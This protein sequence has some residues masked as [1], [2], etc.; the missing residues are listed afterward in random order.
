MRA[1][2]PWPRI[3]FGQSEAHT[4]SGV[5]TNNVGHL[6]LRMP[7]NRSRCQVVRRVALIACIDMA[8]YTVWLPLLRSTRIR[9]SHLRL[10]DCQARGNP[11]ILHTPLDALSSA[12]I[13]PTP[14][15]EGTLGHCHSPESLLSSFAYYPAWPTSIHLPFRAL[16]TTAS[17]DAS[18]LSVYPH[19]QP[20][21]RA[22]RYKVS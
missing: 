3:H 2:W 9:Q 13:S 14:H 17:S 15:P 10:Y 1:T 5:S 20:I 21:Q 6:C 19:H 8:R 12:S 16:P 4:E 18:E 7:Q 22:N 11:E